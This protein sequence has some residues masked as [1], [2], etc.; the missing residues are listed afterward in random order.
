MSGGSSGPSWPM[1]T[2]SV[3]AGVGAGYVVGV[4]TAKWWRSRSQASQEGGLSHPA[5]VTA[6]SDLTSQV[7]DLRVVV[8][9]MQQT[10]RRA[11]P[12]G[13]ESIVSD[14]VSAHAESDDEF[15]DIQ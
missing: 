2:A 4:L 9:E 13:P 15:F 1:T 14:Y 7:R 10:R 12:L 3:L 5:I 6:L 11:R 8:L